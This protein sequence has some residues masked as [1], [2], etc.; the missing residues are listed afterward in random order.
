MR[1]MLHFVW[2]K[3]K[4]VCSDGSR[5]RDCLSVAEVYLVCPLPPHPRRAWEVYRRLEFEF[6]KH[7]AEFVINHTSTLSFLIVSAMRVFL[8]M[9]GNF[10]DVF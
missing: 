3:V 8:T 2:R 4:V 1:L 6:T 10:S 7:C 9:T 5:S